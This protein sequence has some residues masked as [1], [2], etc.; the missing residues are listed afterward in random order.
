[1]AELHWRELLLDERAEGRRVDVYL[2]L[3]FEGFSRAAMARFVSEGA[4]L[5]VGR[6][7]K[8]SSLLRTGERLRIL[9]PGIA[10]ESAPPEL[11][12][13]VYE[14]DRLI[15][16]DK[17]AGMLVHPAGQKFVYAL[18]GLARRARPIPSLDLV[19][20]LDRETSGVV[21]L[22]KDVE[23]NAHVKNAIRHHQVSKTYQA[24]VRGV[25][26]WESTLVD[27][28]IGSSPSSIVRVR[29][30]VVPHGLPSKTEVRVLQRM[31][32]HT[33]VECRPISGRTHQ[34]RLHLE[35]TGFPILGDKLYGQPDDV[36][37]EWLREGATERVKEAIG[38]PRHAL[39]A[40]SL[41]FPHP[42]GSPLRIHAPLA[43]DMR[44]IV[45]GAAAAWV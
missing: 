39:H 42:R 10:P 23:A 41:V 5:S 9:I 35:Y 37:L 7:L 40:A 29:R 13:I 24:I 22:A 8:P 6:T 1:M 11:P 31:A 21:L 43:G 30:A 19:H 12:P 20:R 4:V 2:S 18:I 27:A 32:A 38:F 45:E 28:P 33:L 36:F 16:F 25:V 26:P 14:D 17:P 3:R 15:A 34:I 44:A